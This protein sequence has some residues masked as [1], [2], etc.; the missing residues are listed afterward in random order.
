M[1][2]KTATQDM[3]DTFRRSPEMVIMDTEQTCWEGSW[4]R[5]LAGLP[6]PTDLREVIQIGAV[7]VDTRTFAVLDSFELVVR[8]K[9]NPDLSDFCQSFTGITQARLD[10]EGI[11]FQDALDRFEAF[12]RGAPVLVYNADAE[13][14]RENAEINGVARSIPDYMRIRERLVAIGIDMDGV[15]SGAIARHLGS[16]KTYREHDA[17]ADVVS[18]ADGLAILS[19]LVSGS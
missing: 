15:N 3:L 9:V 7:R 14:F 2:D 1:I 6:L 19:D 5:R 4:E 12:G 11:S 16:T 8:P 18:M 17:L 10:A 13:V